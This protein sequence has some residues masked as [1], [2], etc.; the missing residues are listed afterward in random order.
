MRKRTKLT[1]TFY[2]DAGHGWLKAPAAL[3][4]ELNLKD[5]ITSFS[6]L[7]NKDVFLEEDCDA[8][9]LLNALE[10]IG[11]KVRI[12]ERHTDKSSKIRSYDRYSRVA[13]FK[14]GF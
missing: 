6:K 14:L 8:P 5:K 9:V 3:L 7:R 13:A 4:D 12:V 11:C 10:G 1:L 2:S